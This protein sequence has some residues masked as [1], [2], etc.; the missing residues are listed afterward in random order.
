MFKNTIL[1]N[2]RD[3][4]SEYQ[5]EFIAICCCDMIYDSF[6]LSDNILLK[7]A[8]IVFWTLSTVLDFES[9]TTDTFQRKNNMLVS[10]LLGF[11]LS[12]FSFDVAHID[13]SLK[14]DGWPHEFH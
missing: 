8:K 2:F 12:T 3:L 6:D 5:N 4:N 1:A 11:K 13:I 10:K 9:L 14:E 7:L